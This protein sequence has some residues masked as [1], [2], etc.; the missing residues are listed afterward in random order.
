MNE[1]FFDGDDKAK[2][3][4]VA[5]NIRS[6]K[7]GKNQGLVLTDNGTNREVWTWGANT[8]TTPVKLILDLDSPVVSIAAG[9]GKNM[10]ITENATV[11]EWDA[12]ATQVNSNNIVSK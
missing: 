7:A 5:K 4:Y 2:D 3:I 9:D 1:V 11:Y 8:F 6:I 12:T 10:L